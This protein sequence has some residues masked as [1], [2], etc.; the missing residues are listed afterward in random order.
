MLRLLPR[1]VHEPSVALSCHEQVAR[2]RELPPDS[3]SAKAEV[4]TVA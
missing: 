3:G 1:C 4:G 2:S